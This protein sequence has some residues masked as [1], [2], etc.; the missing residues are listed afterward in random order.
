M[1]VGKR[2]GKPAVLRVAA[3]EMQGDGFKF[4]CADNGVWLT[5][6]VPPRFLRQIS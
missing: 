3:I 1:Q 4:Y 6:S 5:D 2:H